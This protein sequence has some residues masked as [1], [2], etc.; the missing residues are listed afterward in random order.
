M[1]NPQVYIIHKDVRPSSHQKNHFFSKKKK[2]L[3]RKKISPKKRRKNCYPLTFPIL[4]GCDSTR[5]L[6]SS[7]FPNPGGVVRAWRRTKEILVSNFGYIRNIFLKPSF[8][9]CTYIYFCFYE[10]FVPR[11]LK[12]LGNKFSLHLMKLFSEFNIIWIKLHWTSLQPWGKPLE[13]ISYVSRNVECVTTT[14]YTSG[15]T[16]V[17]PKKPGYEKHN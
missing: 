14:I 8:T 5:A 16:S 17:F 15:F 2:N 12:V 3:G 7:P 1:D 6:Q 4:G 13:D 9:C 11:I 10:I